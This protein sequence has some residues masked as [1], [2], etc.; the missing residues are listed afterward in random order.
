MNCKTAIV[1]ATGLIA[2]C[3]GFHPVPSLDRSGEL[4]ATTRDYTT[5]HVVWGED[6]CGLGKAM[7]QGG[8][9]G[10]QAAMIAIPL[11]TLL[12]AYPLM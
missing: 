9:S 2:G 6:F 11:P 12:L 8:W 10:G 5:R 4:Y 7:V 3:K 1:L